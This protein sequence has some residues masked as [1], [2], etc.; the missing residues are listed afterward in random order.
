MLLPIATKHVVNHN[1]PFWSTT[2]NHLLLTD[3]DKKNL[4]TSKSLQMILQ[5]QLSMS[6]WPKLVFVANHQ[7]LSNT[8]PS[9]LYVHVH[10]EADVDVN[11]NVDIDVDIVDCVNVDVNVIIL[12][13]ISAVRIATLTAMN[14]LF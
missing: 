8:F 10:A 1:Q 14:M 13:R 2:T 7:I 4:L 11:I 6:V 9:L 12:M 3:H 5:M